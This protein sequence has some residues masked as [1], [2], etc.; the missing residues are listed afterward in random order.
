VQHN[1]ALRRHVCQ[2]RR[3]RRSPVFA[4]RRC[5]LACPSVSSVLSAASFVIGATPP[6]HSRAS[7]N[8]AFPRACAGMQALLSPLYF[9]L[10]PLYSPSAC[11]DSRGRATL[12]LRARNLLSYFCSSCGCGARRFFTVMIKSPSL[13]VMSHAVSHCVRT[14]LKPIS[15][16]RFSRSF[17][18][19]AP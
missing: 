15:F 4:R 6:R 17:M 7:G 18:W 9:L 19:A 3:R 16:T 10:S 2:Q 8:P 12:R 5:L 1:I 11:G 14:Y 13:A